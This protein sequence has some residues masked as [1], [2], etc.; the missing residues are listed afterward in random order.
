MTPQIT[1]IIPTY[2]RPKLLKRAIE[3]AL[4]Q[5]YPHIQVLVLDNDSNDG[6]KEQVQAMMKK[7]AR[8]IYHCHKTNIGANANFKFGL[9]QVKTPY[10]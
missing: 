1:T 5:S 4:N 9:E 6:T 8:I 2:R 7:D 3:S 10:F